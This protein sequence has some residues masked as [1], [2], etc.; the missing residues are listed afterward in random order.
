MTGAVTGEL[1]AFRRGQA[2][3]AATGRHDEPAGPDDARSRRRADRRNRKIY[4][5]TT[6]G[7]ARLHEL[8]VTA[9]PTD[10]RS[11][12]LQLTFCRELTPPDRITVLERRRAHLA[13]RREAT[14][15]RA[16]G[17]HDLYVRSLREHQ[18]QTLD[19]D[20]RWLDGLI[21]QTRDDRSTTVG[22]GAVTPAKETP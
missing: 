19:D 1:A 16:D 21:A 5:I 8:L 15:T 12:H 9:D 3:A 4:G 14:G 2:M 17:D 13:E 22:A 10:D 18:A 7:Q 11:F 20:L 6:R